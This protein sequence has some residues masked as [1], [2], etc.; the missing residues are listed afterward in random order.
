[1]A[2]ATL[3]E[4]LELPGGASPAGA[5]VTLRLV[6]TDDGNAVAYAGSLG[7]LWAE[8]T[9]VASDGSWSIAN[10]R[11]NTGVSGDVITSPTNTAYQV[12]VKLPSG[13]PVS[14][15]YVR[16]PDSVGPHDVA[17]VLVV[18]PGAILDSAVE[19]T[20]LSQHGFVQQFLNDG[21]IDD[22]L[23][24]WTDASVASSS[25]D[26]LAVLGGKLVVPDPDD[27]P[28]DGTNPAAHGFIYQDFSWLGS[29]V[30]ERV[31]IS[32][33]W[34][35]ERPYE[36]TPLLHVVIGT[37]ETGQGVWPVNDVHPAQGA[38]SGIFHGSIGLDNTK[39]EDLIQR[40][41]LFT[42]LPDELGAMAVQR[43]YHFD[44]RSWDGEWSLWIDGYRVG[45]WLPIPDALVGS[46]VH[47]IALDN[48]QSDENAGAGGTRP[49]NK[50]AWEGPLV[51]ARLMT[52][53]GEPVVPSRQLNDALRYKADTRNV[54]DLAG[55]TMTGALTVE[56]D[57]VGTVA[58]DDDGLGGA[59]VTITQAGDAATSAGL[60][61][62]LGQGT[63]SLG[64]GTGNQA[65]LIAAGD[66]VLSTPGK[67][68][69]GVA[70]SASTDL[71]RF[72][73]VVVKALYDAHSI[74][75][76]TSDNTPVALTVDTS[77]VVGRASSGG[78]VALTPAQLRTIIDLTA[79]IAAAAVGGDLTGTVSN[80][81]IAAGAI[82]NADINAAAAIDG[83]KVNYA[84][85]NAQG[86]TEL[87]TDAEA[88]ALASTARV[89]TPSNL[90]A[91]LAALFAADM[92]CTSDRLSLENADGKV[93]MET[94]AND[95]ASTNYYRGAE[96]H[97]RVVAGHLGQF[98]LSGLFAG[99]GVAD[100]DTYWFRSL[101]TAGVWTAN[102]GG[103]EGIG[104][105][106]VF[107]EQADPSAPA[108]NGATLYARDNGAGKT[109]LCVRF[110]TGAV[111]VI[112]TQP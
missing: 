38:Q 64:D 109:Q 88:L 12:R 47:G 70:A 100:P 23:P 104:K 110:A 39:F 44:L 13:A 33:Y 21:E 46:T 81:Q 57:G 29:W 53:E 18:D 97:P 56:L 41:T 11:P 99:L 87:A 61:S 68:Q 17:D 58:I 42:A 34:T 55:D 85:T 72:G 16:I 20:I 105:G 27:G 35:G 89:L 59:S 96:T 108:A 112:A 15:R 94:D 79:Q 45:D 67:L 25:F 3:Q 65:Y 2:L 60:G 48:N 102:G 84:T 54:V 98:S 103:I 107:A 106:V 62:I 50:G 75:A 111:Q 76:A 26:R 7:V 90:A 92:T 83:T 6:A 49:P 32:G 77:S 1:M 51:V 31:S 10:L 63:L 24:D 4:T 74:L 101:T 36:A 71:V 66:D 69:Q 5:V 80:A 82:V 37:D 86:A 93:R 30:G 28:I 73:E 43:R 40:T 52:K 22:V 91:V 78:I 8:S 95:S 14:P 19:Q 9:V